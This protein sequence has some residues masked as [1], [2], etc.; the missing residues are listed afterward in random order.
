MNFAGVVLF[1]SGIVCLIVSGFM[2]YK[3]IPRE[4]RPPPAWMKSETGETVMALG[5]FI[6]LVVGVALLAKAVL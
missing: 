2:M 6:L 1:L 4:G 5:Q 3:L